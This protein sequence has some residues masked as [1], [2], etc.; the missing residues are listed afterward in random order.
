[1]NG[2]RVVERLRVTVGDRQTVSLAGLHLVGEVADAIGLASA[3]SGAVSVPGVV[4]DRG[5]LLTQVALMLAAGGR[6][7][8]DMDAL[9]DQPAVFGDVASS[10]TIWRTFMSID[11]SRLAGLRDAR[12]R[13]HANRCGRR[14][15]CRRR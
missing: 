12:V 13:A 4:H 2:T 6:C 10:P 14:G 1:M 5:R 7:V 8:A 15:G 3:L 11:H 9:R